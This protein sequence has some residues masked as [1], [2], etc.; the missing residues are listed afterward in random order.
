MRKYARTPE[1]SEQYFVWR[2]IKVC[3]ALGHCR[4]WFNCTT[5]DAPNRTRVGAPAGTHWMW[6]LDYAHREGWTST[7]GF[8]AGS[9]HVSVLVQLARKMTMPVREDQALSSMRSTKGGGG[10]PVVWPLVNKRG[11]PRDG[12]P[13]RMLLYPDGC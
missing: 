7:Q 10:A 8:E 5:W 9:G 6:T 11:G 3:D 1:M 4:R 2:S 13:Q 12:K